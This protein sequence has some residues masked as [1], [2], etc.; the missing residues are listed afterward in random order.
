METGLRN[1]V[2]IIAASSKG[3]GR[4]TAFALRLRQGLS[5]GRVWQNLLAWSCANLL[6][7]GRAGTVKISPRTYSMLVGSQSYPVLLVSWQRETNSFETA[8]Q[9]SG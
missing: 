2:A 3:I 9:L 8:G 5:L 1:R 7:G 6:P 4:A